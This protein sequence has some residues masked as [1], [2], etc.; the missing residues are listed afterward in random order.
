MAKNLNTCKYKSKWK[1]H[2]KSK[3][4]EIYEV[5]QVWTKSII[6]FLPAYVDWT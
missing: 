1:V 3:D 5:L 4:Y 6:M 2:L